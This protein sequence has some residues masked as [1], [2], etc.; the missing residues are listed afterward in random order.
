MSDKELNDLL[1]LIKMVKI[2]HR[3]MLTD[4]KTRV[5]MLGNSGNYT[6]ELLH[7][8]EVQKILEMF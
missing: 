7:A 3:W 8:I 5:D 1:E 4:I 6:D 2:S